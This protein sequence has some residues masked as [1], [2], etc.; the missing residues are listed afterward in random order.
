MTAIDPHSTEAFV[1]QFFSGKHCDDP[2]PDGFQLALEVMK[3]AGFVEG[4]FVHKGHQLTPKGWAR[5]GPDG[6][7]RTMPELRR[8]ASDP[9]TPA[10]RLRVLSHTDLPAV[11]AAVWRNGSLPN[12]LLCQQ[13]TQGRLLDVVLNPTLDLVLLLDPGNLGLRMGLDRRCPLLAA[14]MLRASPAEEGLAIVRDWW[15]EAMA[16]ATRSQRDALTEVRG[17]IHARRKLDEP[18]SP[19]ANP[20][21]P[22]PHPA[23]LASVV[24][25]TCAIA[26]DPG[27]T[28]LDLA[29]RLQ[30]LPRRDSVGLSAGVQDVVLARLEALL[31]R[32]APLGAATPARAA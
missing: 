29:R 20:K 27:R 7:V 31:G 18:R 17:A 24:E 30:P 12:D 19:Y 28:G 9:T 32:P 23:S 25:Q 26:P 16:W 10:A 2:L 11:A 4:D 5:L 8:E 22:H 21:S 1:L 3:Q 15:P 14:A 13:L 6:L